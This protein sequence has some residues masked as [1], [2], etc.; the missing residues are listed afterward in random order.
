LRSRRKQKWA[1]SGKTCGIAVKEQSMNN[2]IA[3]I[4]AGR[5]SEAWI[6][7][8]ISS[9]NLSADQIMACDPSND[10][11]DQL[12]SRYPGLNTSTSNPDGAR[13]GSIVVIATPPPEVIPALAQVRPMLRAEATVISL[14]AGIPMD[15]LV[16]AAPDITV[17]RVMPNTPSMV[18]EG[19]NLVCYAPGTA[20]DVRKR[21]Q[22]LLANFGNSLEIDE[23]DM[24]AYGALCSV[25]PTFL[26]PI[27]QS[28][29]DSAVE[30]GLSESLA[31]MAAA[32]VFV[33][34]GRLVA[35]SERTVA[36]LNSM[37]GLHTLPEPQ[38]MQLMA[39]AYK[40]ALGKLKGLAAR[41]AAGA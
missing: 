39:T 27:V 34:T 31:R 40:D 18:G 33:G 8:L 11:V 20:D 32:Q 38:A 12:R 30:A 3:F 14:A 16:K 21:V 4:G 37:I 19:M 28:L 25:G 24:E 36:E 13:F 22:S 35:S 29:I 7:R 1:E 15:T 5:I 2:T 41:M 10:R 6:E 9:G 17:L 23:R 26:F